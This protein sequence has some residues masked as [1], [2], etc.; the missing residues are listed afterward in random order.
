M[1]EGE[2]RSHEVANE[3]VTNVDASTPTRNVRTV[4]P[5]GFTDNTEDNRDNEVSLLATLN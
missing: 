4:N 2:E 5:N 1:A 3:A